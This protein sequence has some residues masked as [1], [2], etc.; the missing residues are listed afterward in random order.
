MIEIKARWYDGPLFLLF[1]RF[2]AR[3]ATERSARFRAALL[4][5]KER[6]EAGD[7]EEMLLRWAR[8]LGLNAQEARAVVGAGQGP[9]SG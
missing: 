4:L 5:I 3:R 1:P 6:R 7:T 9:Q 8:S 2:A